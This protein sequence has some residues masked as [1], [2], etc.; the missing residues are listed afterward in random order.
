MTLVGQDIRGALLPNT[1]APPLHFPTLGKSWT[2]AKI[3]TLIDTPDILNKIMLPLQI[4]ATGI[5]S[6]TLHSALRVTRNIDPYFLFQV[7]QQP[8]G[9]EK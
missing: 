8:Y 5:Y 4:G 3:L 7:N 9:I 1:L 2:A 6:F